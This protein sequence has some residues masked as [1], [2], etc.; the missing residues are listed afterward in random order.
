MWKKPEYNK[1]QINN[2]G[3]MIIN[4]DATQ[5][6]YEEALEVIDNWRA[7][8]AYPM[9]TFAVNLKRQVSDIEGAIVARR[10]KRL[11][12]ICK[13]LVRFPKMNLYRIQDLGGCRVIVP[14]VADVYTV[15][16]RLEKSRIRHEPKPSK[17]YIQA[18]KPDTGYRGI[19][20]IYKYR[21]EKNKDYNGLLVEIQIRSKL[22][23]LWAT[24]VETVGVFTG[25]GLKFNQGEEDWLFFFRLVSA[26]F[27]VEEGTPIG[28]G[29]PNDI[30]ELIDLLSFMDKKLNA[31]EKMHTIGIAT[32][33]VGHVAKKTI[34][35]YY[36]LILDMEKLTIS[37]K[38][39]EGIE[40]GLNDATNA[41]NEFERK[42]TDKQDAVLVSAE[43][44]ES[45][46]DAYPNYFAN[47]HEFV[48][49][50]FKVFTKQCELL[51]E[52]LV[53]QNRILREKLEAANN[54]S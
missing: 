21:S 27:A 1:K 36:L 34:N 39:F 14:S 17:D 3:L 42:K 46:V 22:Q 50:Y 15:K 11:D 35:G 33:S 12:T 26:L 43:S 54:C 19:H 48:I 40:K 25:N 28:E 24:A 23:H 7:A 52:K 53:E 4:P 13:K 10:L 20:L 9:H 8:H 18:P 31:I 30:G 51:T 44:Y 2:A 41:Y 47:I 49:T 16:E 38:T 32:E 29:V 5:K 45:L 37:V 6:E